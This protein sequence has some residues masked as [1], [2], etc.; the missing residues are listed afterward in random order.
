MVLLIECNSI[1]I[2]IFEKGVCAEDFR[3]LDELI[4][5]VRTLKERFL[6]EDLKRG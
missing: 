2:Q 5:V 1:L 3:D 6:L 4:E